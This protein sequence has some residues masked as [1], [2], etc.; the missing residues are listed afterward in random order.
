MYDG[1]SIGE[2][3]VA[4]GALRAAT[5]AVARRTAPRR[6]SEL[7][8]WDRPSCASAIARYRTAA[9]VTLPRG[10]AD[11]PIGGLWLHFMQWLED[12]LVP[13]LPDLGG[14]AAPLVVKQAINYCPNNGAFDLIPI[15]VGTVY[16]DGESVVIRPGTGMAVG[17]NP[18]FDAMTVTFT[19]DPDGA[20]GYINFERGKRVG[21]LSCDDCESAL[22]SYLL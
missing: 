22:A 14:E 19:V 5:T 17:W 13:Q 9:A 2:A 7:A 15:H 6:V 1:D 16:P 10:V 11:I 12:D 21:K 18:C 20:Q 4:S 8:C 3:P